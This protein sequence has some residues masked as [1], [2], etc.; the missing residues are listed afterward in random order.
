MGLPSAS[1]MTAET[2][3][4]QIR[5]W[6]GPMPQR[7]NALSWFGPLRAEPR[8]AADPADRHLLAAARDGCVLG[9][10]EDRSRRAIEAI[11]KR[12]QRSPAIE[13]RPE[14]HGA[15]VAL[16]FGDMT[17][18]GRCVERCQAPRQRRRLASGDA[19]TI[20]G[21]DDV[22]QARLPP[23]VERRTPAQ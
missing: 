13:R 22:W 14:R 17:E 1:A 12:P 10:D 5:P 16:G 6:Q 7:V 21:N 2:I 9:R 11:E 23:R 3:G 15:A 4:P 20:T 18:P 8:G 19:A